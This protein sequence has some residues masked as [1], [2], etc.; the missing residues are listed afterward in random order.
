VSGRPTAGQGEVS[1][2]E[3][4]TDPRKRITE[5]SLRGT[6]EASRGGGRK[7]SVARGDT[8]A[9]RRR[10]AA[11][12]WL[13]GL[14]DSVWA[15]IALKALGVFVGMLALAGVGASSLARGAG[16]PVPAGSGG[17]GGAVAAGLG[18]LAKVEPGRAAPRASAPPRAPLASPPAD[19]GT[20]AARDAGEDASASTPGGVTA[21]GKVILNRAGVD[22]LCLLP[23]VGPKRAQAILDLRTKLGGRFKRMA[24][25][26][27]LKGIGHKGL[28]KI[29]AKAVLD[30]P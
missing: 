30:A 19:A 2:M 27:R 23:G 7:A 4:V 8:S 9:E 21:D 1:T 29:E 26:L 14:R 20:G 6:S 17:P 5:R 24:D 13:R 25:L 22:E 16:V 18:V 15:P 11:L 10:F 28:R 3:T 12:G